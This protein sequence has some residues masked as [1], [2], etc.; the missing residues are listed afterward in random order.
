M[1]PNEL[2]PPSA[3]PRKPRCSSVRDLRAASAPGI[4]GYR[5]PA[6]LRTFLPSARAPLHCQ[7]Q[8]FRLG[9]G[10]L[11]KWLLFCLFFP[12]LMLFAK[13]CE[14]TV[15]KRVLKEL[16]KIV[17]NTIERQIVLPPLTDQTVSHPALCLRDS[18]SVRATIHIY[19]QVSPPLFPFSDSMQ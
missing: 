9:G 15:L 10:V 13:I 6:C 3:V 18:H 16:W 5:A 11:T 17:L 2:L 8:S 4:R 1:S 14:K 12:S 19:H 7:G